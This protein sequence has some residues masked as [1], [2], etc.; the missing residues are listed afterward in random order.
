MRSSVRRLPL[1]AVCSAMLL[2]SLTAAL[3]AAG[4]PGDVNG[5]G[6]VDCSDVALVKRAFG[7]KAGQPGF[8]ARADLV[9]DGV[10]DVRD[11]AFVTKYL[12]SGTHCPE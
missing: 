6:K 2:I 8:D 4:V 3:F 7:K 1:F 9:K 5:D 12:P 10:I 11:L